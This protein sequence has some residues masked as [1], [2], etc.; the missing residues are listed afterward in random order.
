[1]KSSTQGFTVVLAV[2]VAAMFASIVPPFSGLVS[3]AANNMYPYPGPDVHFDFFIGGLLGLLCGVLILF[4]PFEP[5]S[6]PTVLVCWA[7]KLS[8]ALFLVPVYEYAYGMDLDGYFFFDEKPVNPHNLRFASGTWNV[9]LLAWMVFRVIG[10]SFHGGKVLFTFVGFIGIYLAYR[11]A[12]AFLKEESPKLFMLMSLVPT[13]LFWAST[14]GKDP[15]NL[16]G[17]G[18]YSYGCFHL[19]DKPR[20]RLLLP[21]FAGAALASHVRP[22]FLPIMGIPLA[23]AFLA[24]SRHHV[25]RLL[26]LPF[27]LAG[28]NYSV[29]TFQN[30]M[31]VDSFESFAKYQSKV[32][33][34]WVGGSSFSLPTIDTPVKALIVSPFAIFTA[35]FR[36]TLFEAHNPFAFASALDN[37]VLLILFFYAIVR[38]RFREIFK[39]E[40]IWMSAFVVVWAIMY[41][42][43]TGNLGAISRFKIQ[44]LPVFIVLLVYMARKRQMNVPTPQA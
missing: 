3:L 9:R 32:A 21:I 7:V 17:V 19:F 34:N 43:G 41:G 4:G 1:M 13:S 31:E 36:P 39:P 44:V 6:R 42:L 37:T 11:G 12:V 33:A 2:S 23:F 25:I 10:P 26:I 35:L 28:M 27:I 24:Q 5:T 16:L 20:P 18:L 29:R 30:A 22:Y 8:S 38:S 15:V 14:L 40:T